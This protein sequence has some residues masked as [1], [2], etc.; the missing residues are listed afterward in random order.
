[1]RN[2]LKD[3][4]EVAHYWANK[5]QESGRNSTNNIRFRDGKLYSYSME[6]AA[7]RQLPD[8]TEVVFIVRESRSNTT[9]GHQLDA[10][11]AW[12]EY[13]D[14]FLEQFESSL[15][16]KYSR[17]KESRLN[18]AEDWA[19]KANQIA[20]TF[21]LNV[22]LLSIDVAPEVRVAMELEAKE[23]AEKE[24]E[25]KQVRNLELKEKRDRWLSGE[26][27]I[28]YPQAHD[29]DIQLRVNP[30]DPDEVET[31]RGARVPVAVCRR[32]YKSWKRQQMPEDTSVGVYRLDRVDKH[33]L[34]IGCHEISNKEIERFA[35]VLWG[36]E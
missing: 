20:A 11:S 29:V 24:K 4:S 34:K 10:I 33:G 1:M 36:G 26:L 28:G 15:L 16:P 2:V 12:E 35:K 8:G 21:N 32:L 18:Q 13:R 22:E 25:A 27:Y 17:T 6:I 30:L 31:S 23:K 5:V 7:F 3:S 9:T 19:N 14:K